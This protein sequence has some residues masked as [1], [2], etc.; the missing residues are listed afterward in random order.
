MDDK[1]TQFE[2]YL[3]KSVADLGTLMTCPEMTKNA[4]AVMKINRFRAYLL[5]LQRNQETNV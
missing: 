3:F 5:D 1:V 4:R 2:E